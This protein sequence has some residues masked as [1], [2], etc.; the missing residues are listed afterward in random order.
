MSIG[1]PVANRD[2]L[3]LEGLVGFFVNTAVLRTVIDPT[4]SFRRLVTEVAKVVDGAFAHQELPFE[5][6]V[7]ELRPH[8][9]AME[10]REAPPTAAEMHEHIDRWL[11]AS[12]FFDAESGLIDADALAPCL[13]EDVP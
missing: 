2:R 5:Q 4:W 6:L 1:T 11:R 12:D 8:V 13:S 10:E 3:E 9:E 7:D